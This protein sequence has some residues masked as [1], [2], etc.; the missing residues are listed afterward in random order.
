MKCIR[1]PIHLEAMQWNGP[2]DNDK[3]RAFA[4]HWA[5][6]AD[7]QDAVL[8]TSFRGVC[9]VMPGDYV[10]REMNGE[11]IVFTEEAFN[12]WFEPVVED[13]RPTWDGPGGAKIPVSMGFPS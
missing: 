9:Q 13:T 2:A 4:D 7:S 12:N 6:I 1:K 5:S 3:L 8:V 10:V 11:Y